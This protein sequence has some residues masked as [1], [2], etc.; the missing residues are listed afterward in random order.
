[1]SSQRCIT[2]FQVVRG[3]MTEF[4]AYLACATTKHPCQSLWSLPPAGFVDGLHLLTT[5]RVEPLSAA[6]PLWS[7]ISSIVYIII[8]FSILYLYAVMARVY[9]TWVARFRYVLFFALL[10]PSINL[11][12]SLPFPSLPFPPLLSPLSS[13][14]C[15]ALLCSPHL[16]SSLILSS[17]LSPLFSSLLF[18]YILFSFSLIF[19][20]YVFLLYSLIMF[21][22]YILL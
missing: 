3:K 19:S 5:R 4:V 18:S 21:F 2:R 16:F 20:Y 14:L 9:K 8:I 6:S 11:F 15:S 7:W 13:P 17:L 12:P 22:S 10:F 1:M